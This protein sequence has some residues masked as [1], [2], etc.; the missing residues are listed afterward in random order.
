MMQAFPTKSVHPSL[1]AW[2][3]SLVS[4]FKPLLLLPSPLLFLSPPD[5]SRLPQSEI[6]GALAPSRPPACVLSAAAADPEWVARWAGDRL[7]DVTP[8]PRHARLRIRLAEEAPATT[9][10]P[11]ERA[12]ARPGTDG[13]KAMEDGGTLALFGNGWKE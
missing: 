12:S 9:L 6:G 13:M 10:S 11:S 2:P 3:P 8:P 5:L 1:A 7:E 4:S